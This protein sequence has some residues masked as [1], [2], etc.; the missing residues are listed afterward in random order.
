MVYQNQKWHEQIILQEAKDLSQ[1]EN[2]SSEPSLENKKFQN[3]IQ[4]N[5]L[6]NTSNMLIKNNNPKLD[7]IKNLM[8][9]KIYKKNMN[10]VFRK[11]T[12][13]LEK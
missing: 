2:E 6:Q 1:Y 13:N 3:Q 8:L 4:D 7:F 5:L 11:I 9:L 10:K 12:R